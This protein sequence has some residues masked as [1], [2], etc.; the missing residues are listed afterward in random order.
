[1]AIT[2]VGNIAY[3][4]QN[5]LLNSQMQAANLNAAN[6]QT[7][8]NMKEFSEKMQENLEVRATEESKAIDKDGQNSNKQEYE[9]D[10]NNSESPPKAHKKEHLN[11]YG[12]DG[13]LDI[14][15]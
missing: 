2:Q 3:I 1:M 8:I 6:A 14:D 9:S 7:A 12:E 10:S 13:I 11:I 4:N 15:V 5:T